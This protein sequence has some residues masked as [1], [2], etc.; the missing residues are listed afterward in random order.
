MVG[1][2]IFTFGLEIIGGKIMGIS[3]GSGANSGSGSGSGFISELIIG[4]VSEE[5]PKSSADTSS[6]VVVSSGTISTSSMTSIGF[7]VT[8][9][10][11]VLETL[12]EN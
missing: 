10:M 7:G 5:K 9:S 2:L 11:G 1:N 12:S 8:I 4:G 6:K 3:S